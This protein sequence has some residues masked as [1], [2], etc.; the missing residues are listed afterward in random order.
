M[1]LL[2]PETAPADEVW[3]ALDLETTGLSVERDEIIEVG[4]VKFRGDEILDTFTS[5]VNPRRRLDEFIV[6]LTGIPQHEV[7]RAPEFGAVLRPF[8]EFVGQSPVVGH[9][10]PFDLGFLAKSGLPLRNP[11]CDT[12]DLAYVLFPGLPGTH[13]SGSQTASGRETRSLTGRSRTRTR[14]GTCSTCCCA[15]RWSSTPSPWPKWAD[16]PGARPGC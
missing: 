11:R 7:D 15:G 4:A 9:N 3:V 12:W 16:W 10:L 5:L 2:P 1:T 8:A 14:P 13:W 6:R